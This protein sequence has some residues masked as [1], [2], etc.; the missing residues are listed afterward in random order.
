MVDVLVLVGTVLTVEHKVLHI[1]M[2]YE[3]IVYLT[4]LEI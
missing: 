3:G 4:H 2:I 1:V